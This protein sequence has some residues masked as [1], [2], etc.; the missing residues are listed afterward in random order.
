MKLNML[1]LPLA[2]VASCRSSKVEDARTDS[3]GAASEAAIQP[4][5]LHVVRIDASVLTSE[6]LTALNG[7][8][9][10][11]VGFR[12]VRGIM[13]DGTRC[14]EAEL[15]NDSSQELISEDDS[16]RIVYQIQTYDS[17]KWTPVLTCSVAASPQIP[18]LAAHSTTIVQIPLLGDWA[19][20]S[21]RW[22]FALLVRKKEDSQMW[23]M[24][25]CEPRHSPAQDQ[26]WLKFR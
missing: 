1:V 4:A 19:P 20:P 18:T 12:V 26:P 17:D 22:R 14:V 11:N 25:P 13:V 16:G 7:W 24:I 3:A 9:Y 23:W 10:S 6:Q 5:P 21:R 15:V 2:L 8:V